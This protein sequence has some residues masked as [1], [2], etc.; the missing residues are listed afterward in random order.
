MSCSPALDV[1]LLVC[2]STAVVV[3]VVFGPPTSSHI[4]TEGAVRQG[5]SKQVGYK[6][7]PTVVEMG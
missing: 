6:A 1:S 5:D 7:A 2:S 4:D 3:G